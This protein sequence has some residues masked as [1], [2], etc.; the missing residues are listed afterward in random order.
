MKTLNTT[1][2]RSI[3]SGFIDLYSHL[4]TWVA[5]RIRSLAQ[6]SILRN[7]CVSFSF[8]CLSQ[9]ISE[10]L[11]ER[12][13]QRQHWRQLRLIPAPA[14]LCARIDGLRHLRVTRRIDA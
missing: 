7:Q 3:S 8:E 11:N 10:T 5:S 14:A 4:P 6:P 12:L 9:G 1:W 2:T 13:E